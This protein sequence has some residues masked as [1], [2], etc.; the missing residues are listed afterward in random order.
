MGTYWRVS[1]IWQRLEDSMPQTFGRYRSLPTAQESYI[2]GYESGKEWKARGWTHTPG[3]PWICT[4]DLHLWL[5]P[6][7]KEWERFCT[8]TVINN[9]EW[10]QGWRNGL[11]DAEKG[12]ADNPR[13]LYGIG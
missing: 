10:L 12:I 7:D 6:K 13:D 4:F 3:G 5:T 1:L 9:R 2:E 8:A 11:A